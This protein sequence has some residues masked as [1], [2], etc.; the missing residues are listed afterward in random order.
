MLYMARHMFTLEDIL[1]GTNGHLDG[2][3]DNLPTMQF[4][5]VVIDSRHATGG[6]LFFALKGERVDGHDYIV[7]ALANGAFGAV[8]REDW[9]MPDGWMP[10]HPL[11]RVDDPLAA[12]Q[13]LAA[14]WRARHDVQVI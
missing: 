13:R 3:P 4:K 6:S 10:S 14:W 1:Q 9:P 8:V 7:N 12:L 11:I 2:L 5:D